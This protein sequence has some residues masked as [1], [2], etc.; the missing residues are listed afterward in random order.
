MLVNTARRSGERVLAAQLSDLRC[1]FGFV[2]WSD[3]AR[4]VAGEDFSLYLFE[5][6]RQVS[7]YSALHL[8]SPRF[9]EPRCLLLLSMCDHVI[10][11]H[12]RSVL[13]PIGTDAHRWACD[14][15]RQLRAYW[16][17]TNLPT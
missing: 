11:I 8:M 6:I 2:Q 15:T 1:C 3:I 5:G 10:A 12:E 7:N 17:K 13:A 9:D 4:G 16:A 14:P